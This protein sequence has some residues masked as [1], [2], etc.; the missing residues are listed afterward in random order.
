MRDKWSR[1][2]FYPIRTASSDLSRSEDAVF[3][4]CN[5][6][7]VS[8]ATTLYVDSDG[9]TGIQDGSIK[10]AIK[11]KNDK[12]LANAL[13]IEMGNSGDAELLVV[14][15]L[16]YLKSAYYADKANLGVTG[17][18]VIYGADAVM[19]DTGTGNNQG[20]TTTSGN[21]TFTTENKSI[22][23]I[24]SARD[25]SNG[26]V[27]FNLATG[28][29]VNTA[30]LFYTWTVS[31]GNTMIDSAT[32][33]EGYFKDTV[34]VKD[35]APKDGEQVTIA[36]TGIKATG[37][38]EN[39][40]ADDI[41][42]LL[43]QENATVTVTKV[44][45]GEIKGP[46]DATLDLSK[47]TS[48]ETGATVNVAKDGTI[49]LPNGQTL[50]KVTCDLK[51]QANE[52][53]GVDVTVGGTISTDLKIGK[54]DKVILQ[55]GAEVTLTT[56]PEEGATITVAPGAKLTMPNKFVMGEGGTVTCDKEVSIKQ[57][58]NTAMDI[59]VPDGAIVT[60]NETFKF[61]AKDILTLG[62][63]VK[64]VGAKDDVE[65]TFAPTDC[66]KNQDNFYQNGGSNSNKETTVQSATYKWTTDKWVA[67]T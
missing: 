10:T 60:V 56:E 4:G 33:A 22:L 20:G 58:S 24:S 11:D 15:Q 50:S 59:T 67:T 46:A 48:V 1:K 32:V 21:F 55:N 42:N 45:A 54:T 38:S 61:G 3:C 19:D 5:E 30:K 43:T 47:A 8:S 52:D 2:N 64:I 57:N 7:D 13:Y 9:K 63:N 18:D 44:P 39:A 12:L 65:I 14:D 53:K 26:S 29:N 40:T 34:T 27:T 41:N 35:V 6:L 28:S 36:L 17:T 23:N 25:N 62:K 51:L 31:V 66:V 49:T 37:A 16:T